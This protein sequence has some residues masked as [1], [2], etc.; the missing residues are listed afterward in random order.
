MGVVGWGGGGGK[1]EG[2]GVGGWGGGAV[3]ENGR[4][5][6]FKYYTFDAL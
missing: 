3:K 6:E 1:C 2:V 5:G 4:G